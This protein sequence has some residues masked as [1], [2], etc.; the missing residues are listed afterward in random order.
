MAIRKGDD[1]NAFGFSF[2]TIELENASDYTITKAEIRIGTI[3]KTVLNPVFPLYID[4]NSQETLTLSEACNKCYMA[5]YDV[6][7]R[8]W[9]CEGE[10]TFPAKPKV[11]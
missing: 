6:E 4:L 7:N 2:L 10:L 5:I 1:S 9:T 8:K 11:V 3:I